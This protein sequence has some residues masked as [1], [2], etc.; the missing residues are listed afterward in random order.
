[1]CGSL[2][3]VTGKQL[4]Q[5]HDASAQC[6]HC[7]AAGAVSGEYA[8]VYGGNVHKCPSTACVCSVFDRGMTSQN[9][10]QALCC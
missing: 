5:Q 3:V 6:W 1:M 7:K 9:P 2:V 10:I 8:C 4:L